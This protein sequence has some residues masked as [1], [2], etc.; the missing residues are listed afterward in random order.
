MKYIGLIILF[1]SLAVAQ[2]ELSTEIQK[3]ET[4]KV[5]QTQSSESV[6]SAE[7]DIED[8][9]AQE[10]EAPQS[11]ESITETAD[12]PVLEEAPAEEAVE[13]VAAPDTLPEQ[14]FESVEPTVEEALPAEPVVEEPIEE[15]PPAVV[16][17]SAPEETLQP[18]QTAS[19]SSQGTDFEARLN[20]IYNQ[21]YTE[22]LS[23]DAWKQIA[24]EKINESYTIQSGDTL[25]DI[26]VTFF[27]NGHY[28]P[29]VWQLNDDITNP[30]LISSGYQLK[31]VPGT[32]N[33]APQLNI[34]DGSAEAAPVAVASSESQSA[35]PDEELA[36]VIPPPTKKSRSVL[37]SLPPSLPMLVSKK[38]AEFD[39]DGF[40]RQQ[41]RVSIK[42]T[43]V[44]L[45]SYIVDSKPEKLGTVVESD[46]GDIETVGVYDTVFVKIDQGAQPNEKFMIYN[47]GDSIHSKDSG[48]KG[49]QLF[50]NAEIR[51]IEKV[52]EDKNIYK[53]LV[54]KSVFPAKVGAMLMRGS[55]PIANAEESGSSGSTTGEIIGGDYEEERFL[56][57]TQ[58]VVYIDR[59]TEDGVQVGSVYSVRKNNKLRNSNSLVK[60]MRTQIAK[61]K[62]VKTAGQFST[63]IVLNSNEDVRVGDKF[64]AASG[65]AAPIMK[66]IIEEQKSEELP[67][68]ESEEVERDEY[69]EE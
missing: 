18:Q 42:S 65:G 59:G 58:Q 41:S 30:H 54:T 3:L 69:I 45:T 31:F 2:D 49:Y 1:G 24:G 50:C 62:V 17:E 23:E 12:E 38:Y 52:N 13:E 4:G 22:A 6:E 28:W 8:E 33:E 37:K 21:F 14:D 46:I 43:D 27:G 56:F 60:E 10:P 11:T 19:A 63:A 61:I 47:I 40:S 9:L 39:N 26:S 15:A 53:A 16:E 5:E 7:K 66:D 32:L 36:P 29:K 57:G 48:R 44:F 35:A 55:I 64:T 25:W 68:T 67:D 34:T 20:R 51:I